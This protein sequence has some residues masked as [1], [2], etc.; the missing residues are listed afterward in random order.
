MTERKKKGDRE[1]L[2]QNTLPKSEEDQ[3][4]EREA[5]DEC[6]MKRSSKAVLKDLCYESLAFKIWYWTWVRKTV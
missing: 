5:Q 4:L 1:C 2:K 6:E 3:G